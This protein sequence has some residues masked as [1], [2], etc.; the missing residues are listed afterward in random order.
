MGTFRVICLCLAAMPRLVTCLVVHPSAM[1]FAPLRMTPGVAV[2]MQYGQQQGYG[3]QQQGYDQQQGYGAQQQG[4][5]S[6]ALWRLYAAN[7]VCGHNQFSGAVSAVNKDRFGSVAQKYGQLPYTLVAN[8]ERILSKWNMVN[9]QVP[10]SL[11]LTLTLSFDLNPNPNPHS[12]PSPNPNPGP[13]PNPNP[14]LTLSNNQVPTVSRSQC[15]VNLYA[16]G[17]AVLTSHGSCAPTLV[18]AQGGAW[19]AIYADQTHYLTSG[20][21][22]SLDASNP[23][24]AVFT[25]QNEAGGADQQQGQ[26]GGYGQQQGGYGQQQQGGYGQQQG[27]PQQGGNGY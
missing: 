18:R 5:G 2:K 24:G 9:N 1:T 7:G 19:I 11:T 26:Q 27:Y 16:D 23:E 22:I 17:T 3:G 13:N 20:D 4:Y 14:T 15:K 6:Q 21:Q 25:C 12:A 10:P 8:D